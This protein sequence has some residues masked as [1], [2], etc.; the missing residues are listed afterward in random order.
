MNAD[1]LSRFHPLVTEWFSDRFG[2]PTEAQARAW[3]EIASGGHVLITAPT[4][5]GKTLTAF[6]WALDQLITGRW[7]VDRTSVLYI[8]PLKALNQDIQRNLIQPLE[9]LKQVFESAGQPFP[10]I[11]ALTRSGDTPQGDRRRMQRRPPEI[12]ITTPESLNILLS[13]AGG[14]SL[15]TGLKTV[16]LDEIHAVFGNKRG[17]HLI[18][19]VDRL[20][21]LC[22]EFQRVALSATINPLEV[23][24][25]FIGGMTRQGPVRVPR[26]SPRP[27][28]IVRAETPKRYEVRVRF[29]DQAVDAGTQ[30][31]VWRPVVEECKKIIGA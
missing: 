27:V 10:E 21:R 30:E 13:S 17:V 2:K 19:A 5:S 9:E 23:V 7:P 31:S 12:L 15:L 20:V 4:G 22:G 8:S 11:R 26:Y 28:T 16:I 24:A 14:R 6:L 25:R 18:T 1:P 29:P 3:P